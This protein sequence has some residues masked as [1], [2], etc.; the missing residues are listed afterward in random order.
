MRRAAPRARNRQRALL[1]GGNDL[2]ILVGARIG[3][4][5]REDVGGRL[6]ANL[7]DGPAVYKRVYLA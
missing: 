3:Q 1:R 5:G 2:F 7:A 4:C 6:V